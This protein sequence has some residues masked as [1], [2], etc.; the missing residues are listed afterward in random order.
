VAASIAKEGGDHP[1]K[2]WPILRKRERRESIRER[3]SEKLRNCS[4]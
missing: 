4:I 3:E 1:G 2:P